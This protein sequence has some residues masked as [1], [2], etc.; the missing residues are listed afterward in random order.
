MA[1][2]L[3]TTGQ[4]SVIQKPTIV[5]VKYKALATVFVFKSWLNWLP[6]PMQVLKK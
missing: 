3:Q 1:V 5:S 4:T 2:K 6:D